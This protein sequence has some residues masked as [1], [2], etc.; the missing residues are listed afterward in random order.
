MNLTE[1]IKQIIHE[2][3]VNNTVYSGLYFSTC[4]VKTYFN[5]SFNFNL[6]NNETDLEDNVKFLLDNIIAKIFE[7]NY[8]IDYS[9]YHRSSLGN[10]IQYDDMKANNPF[11]VNMY[12]FIQPEPFANIEDCMDDIEILEG[13]QRYQI[14][15]KIPIVKLDKKNIKVK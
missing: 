7:I 14:N 10:F 6:P 9:E 13:S 2:T 11:I 5:F 3:T 4:K 15:W 8:K 12:K 1:N